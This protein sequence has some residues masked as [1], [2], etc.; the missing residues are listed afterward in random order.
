MNHQKQQSRIQ[1]RNNNRK[2][3]MKKRTERRNILSMIR[4]TL[5]T[6]RSQR[7]LRRIMMTM[8]RVLMRN[9]TRSTAKL[10]KTGILGHKRS[11]SLPCQHPLNKLVESQ[12]TKL[13]PKMSRG[14]LKNLPSQS[15]KKTPKTQKTRRSKM[16]MMI[17]RSQKRIDN[18]SRKKSAPKASP[19]NLTLV[20]I[21]HP[22]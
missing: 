4:R 2:T 19:T 18:R 3:M 17:K 8:R 14:K 5:K 22:G 10:T 13:T 1:K 15:T 12:L 7:N 21:R 20:K 9:R 6:Q 11:R 16:M